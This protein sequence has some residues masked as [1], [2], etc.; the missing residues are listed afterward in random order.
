LDDP[1][2]WQEV[3]NPAGVDHTK[4]E[5]NVTC[6]T[7]DRHN[8]GSTIAFYASEAKDDQHTD[9]MVTDAV[10]AMMDKHRKEPWFLAAGSTSRIARGSCR[11][12]ISI[13]IPSAASRRRH[14]MKAK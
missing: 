3:V 12:G 13:Y 9:H 1:A 7:P 11:A 4:E 8:L 5:P 2:S 14:S 6:Y 10:I